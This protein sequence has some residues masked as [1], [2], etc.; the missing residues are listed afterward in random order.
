MIYISSDDQIAY[1]H[2]PKNGSRTMLGYLA[3]IKD[4]TLF[5][6]HPEYFHPVNNEVYPELRNRSQRLGKHDF[7]PKDVPV[8]DNP[9]RIV[10]K[11][12]PVKRFVSG[13]TNRVL[14]HNKMRNKPSFDDFVK[15]FNKY[16]ATYSDIQTHFKP[17]VRFFGLDKS[18]YTHVFDTSEMHLVKELLEDTYNRKFPDIRL[19]QGGND[20]RPTVTKEQQE[21]IMEKYRVDY[22]AGWY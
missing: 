1:Y 7:N 21:W 18:I 8:V 14:H 4:P 15:N 19:Q 13:Y 9:I 17:Q 2:A 16:H 6:E 10:V 11:R 12:D 20:K 5:E 22:D 3:L